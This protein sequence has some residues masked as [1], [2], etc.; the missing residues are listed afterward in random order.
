[1]PS[2]PVRRH[3]A[4]PTSPKSAPPARAGAAAAKLEAEI[5]FQTYFKS[6]GPRTYAAQVKK[7]GNGNHFVVLTEGKKDAE[8]GQPRKTRLFVFSEDFRDFF[9]MLQETAV[10]IRE[11]PVPPEIKKKRD[12][13]WA[14]HGENASL[15]GRSSAASAQV[16]VRS[17][18]PQ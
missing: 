8:T 7:A 13:F 1:M 4:A 11:N 6:V 18:K 17:N 16:N 3:P 9:R 2:A 14:K 10:F 12:K 5:L 15:A